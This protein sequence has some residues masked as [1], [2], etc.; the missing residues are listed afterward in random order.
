[1][2]VMKNV[3]GR[4]KKCAT[5]HE[6]VQFEFLAMGGGPSPGGSALPDWTR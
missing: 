6:I 3:L 4:A 1:M 2:S 5:L